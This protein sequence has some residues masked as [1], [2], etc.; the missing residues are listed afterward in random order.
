MLRKRCV[1]GLAI[2]VDSRP[3]N[4]R[5]FSVFLKEPGVYRKQSKLIAS[6][7]SC[8]M[9]APQHYPIL[10]IAAAETAARVE[11]RKSEC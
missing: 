11:S 1:H 9:L 3:E 10:S 2:A 7:G 8:Y 5:G 4:R 6:R